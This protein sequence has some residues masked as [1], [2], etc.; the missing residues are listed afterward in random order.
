MKKTKNGWDVLFSSPLNNHKRGIMMVRDHVRE[1]LMSG[2][3]EGPDIDRHLRRLQ[4]IE[5]LLECRP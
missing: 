1:L 3:L 2:T 4:R 5:R